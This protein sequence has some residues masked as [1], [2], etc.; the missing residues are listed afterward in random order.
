MKTR[1]PTGNEDSNKTRCK[2]CGFLGVDKERDKTGSGSG[3]R[4]ESITH[5]A[6]TAPHNPIVIAGCGFCGTKNY[7]NWSR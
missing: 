1:Q 5:T 3:L 6:S 2:R 4:Y 7:E